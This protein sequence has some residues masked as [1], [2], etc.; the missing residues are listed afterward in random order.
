M[1]TRVDRQLKSTNFD[2][3]GSLPIEILLQILK[4]LDPADIVRNQRVR[5]PSS[6]CPKHIC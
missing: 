4:Y 6:F 1:K 2:V 5:I 3:V